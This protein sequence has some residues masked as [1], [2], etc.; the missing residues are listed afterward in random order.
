MTLDAIAN[1][2]F[3]TAMGAISSGFTDG[4]QQIT[5]NEKRDSLEIANTN[6]K[7]R[8]EIN[9]A[10]AFVMLGNAMGEIAGDVRY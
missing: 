7:N 8:T 3:S 1:T 9:K 5:E 6:Q 2:V 10:K 4:M